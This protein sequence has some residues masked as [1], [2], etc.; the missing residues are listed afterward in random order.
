MAKQIDL[1]MKTLRLPILLGFVMLMISFGLLFCGYRLYYY[2]VVHPFAP[3]IVLG[4]LKGLMFLA[5]ACFGICLYKLWADYR[6]TGFLTDANIRLV[7][8]MGYCALFVSVVNPIFITF[9]KRDELGVAG[10]FL[11]NSLIMFVLESPLMLL[12]GLL[13]Y[14]LAD[15]MQKA[16]AVKRDNESF[17]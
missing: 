8:Y 16:I 13:T 2:A 14:L 10:A 9:E 11:A 6:R 3:A 4:T 17:I 5:L 15:F 1:L 12:V 7:R